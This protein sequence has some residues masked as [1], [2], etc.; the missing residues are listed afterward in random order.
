MYRDNV[1]KLLPRVSNSISSRVALKPGYPQKLCVII[2]S[3]L[4]LLPYKKLPLTVN[5]WR[6]QINFFKKNCLLLLGS[7]HTER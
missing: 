6:L 3:Y 5:N 1:G 7:F 4:L 2:K